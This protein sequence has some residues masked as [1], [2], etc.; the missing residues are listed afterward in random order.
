MGAQESSFDGVV[1]VVDGSCFFLRCRRDGVQELGG[2]GSLGELWLSVCNC[3]GF[4]G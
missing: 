4:G 3:S 1:G 2:A